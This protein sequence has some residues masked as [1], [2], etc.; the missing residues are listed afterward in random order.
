MWKKLV[1]MMRKINKAMDENFD[2]ETYF[3]HLK[4]I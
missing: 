2:T 3:E 4:I 1:A